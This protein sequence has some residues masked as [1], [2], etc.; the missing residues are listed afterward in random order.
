MLYGLGAASVLGPAT[1]ALPDCLSQEL[2]DCLNTDHTAMPKA[3]C[4][5]INAAYAPGVPD[6]TQTAMDHAIN[7]L[8][9]CK[10]PS[11]VPFVGVAFAVGALL[12]ALV[13]KR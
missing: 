1:A 12:G 10:G 2:M 5:A 4:D 11:M 8:P 3:Q 6:A 13:M 9:V 7:A